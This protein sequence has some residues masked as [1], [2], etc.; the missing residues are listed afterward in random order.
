MAIAFVDVSTASLTTVGTAITPAIPSGA[1][2]EVTN[3]N[4]VVLFAAVARQGGALTSNTPTGWTL[5]DTILGGSGTSGQDSVMLTYYKIAVSN[6]T[7]PTFSVTGGTTRFMATIVAYKGVDTTLP[8]EAMTKASGSSATLTATSPAATTALTGVWFL[9]FFAQTKG[10]SGGTFAVDAPV[11][12]RAS[13]TPALLSLATGDEGPSSVNAVARTATSSIAGKWAAQTMVLRPAAARPNAVNQW[14]TQSIGAGPALATPYDV[15]DAKLTW[16]PPDMTGWT[17]LTITNASNSS[18]TLDAN[19]KYRIVIAEKITHGLAFVGAR[20]IAII[21]GEIDFS[22]QPTGRNASAMVGLK[23][24]GNTETVYIEGLWIHGAPH[25]GSGLSSPVAGALGDGINLNGLTSANRLSTVTIQ[26]VRIDYARVDCYDQQVGINA[27]ASNEV[28][29][30]AIQSFGT[31]ANIVRIDKLTADSSLQGLF[32]QGAT[33]N[34]TFDYRRINLDGSRTKYDGTASTG[35]YMLY[36]S[37]SAA[38]AQRT[39]L[40][41]V[42]INGGSVLPTGG[43]PDGRNGYYGW[44][45]GF[46]PGGSFVGLGGS[47]GGPGLSYTSPGYKSNV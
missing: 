2:T 14:V 26:N 11:T 3:G 13:V 18:P 42:Y 8:V 4:A 46:P 40:N 1:L 12:Q 31:I 34:T 36:N 30:D 45:V 16:Q 9:R 7:A 10:S 28:H 5:I 33:T 15:T 20:A 27:Y 17:T 44:N 24:Y 19:T 37:S 32:N 29:P 47:A 23:I 25:D 41:D 35:T 39:V 6:E 22:G 43:L 38:N 21:G